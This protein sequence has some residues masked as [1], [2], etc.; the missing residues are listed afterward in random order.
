M[1]KCLRRS[2]LPATVFLPNLSSETCVAQADCRTVPA[3]DRLHVFSLL[4][5]FRP[6]CAKAIQRFR[7]PT[8]CR[9][10]PFAVARAGILTDLCICTISLLTS[11]GLLPTIPCLCK[12]T[13][14]KGTCHEPDS[15]AGDRLGGAGSG[16]GAVPGNSQPGHFVFCRKAGPRVRF[17]TGRLAPSPGGAT[18]TRSTRASSRISGPIPP[19][20]AR[21]SGRWRPFRTT[22]AIGGWRSRGRRTGR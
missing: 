9:L 2:G 15:I 16:P 11:L 3:D 19:A 22:C 12:P 5:C 14:I 17:P 8:P 4:F 20:S 13:S 6:T 1:A 21:A 18:A 10:D 7:R